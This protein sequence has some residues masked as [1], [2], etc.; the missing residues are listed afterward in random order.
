MM[1]QICGKRPA[2][3]H[4]TR[5]VNGVTTELHVCAQCAAQQ[6]LD[7][8]GGF[9]MD[10][11]SLFGG[12]FSAPAVHGLGETTRCKTCGSSFRDI[13]QS[14]KVG[15]PDCYVTFYEQLL[16]SIQR[17]HGR[18]THAGKVGSNAGSESKTA[19]E[20]ESLKEQLNQAIAAQEYE[21][22]AKLR[23]RIR[24]LEGNDYE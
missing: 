1:C 7:L 8:F 12:L 5:T 2:T 3:T 14:G 4:V 20:L 17:V 18:A 24:Q 22:C 6:G 16:P 11:G 21:Q 10:A 19:R 13:A 23:D 9:G 15:C